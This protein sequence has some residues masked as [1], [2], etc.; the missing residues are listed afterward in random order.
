MEFHARDALRVAGLSYRQLDFCL[1]S[2]AIRP[3]RGGG[4][5]SGSPRRFDWRDL[6]TL[7]L[8]GDVLRA[9]LRVRAVVPA[10]LLVQR[11]HGLPPLDRIRNLCVWTDGS[12]AALVQR[13]R[14]IGTPANAGP[15]AYLLDVAAA[16]ERVRAGVNGLNVTRS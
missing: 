14:V 3:S 5:G 11:G 1:R 13:G 16:A 10:L 15:V 2:G 6:L 8:V 7:V 4:R 9:G 12:R